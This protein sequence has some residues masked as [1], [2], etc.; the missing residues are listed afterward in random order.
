MQAPASAPVPR[1]VRSQDSRAARPPATA[2]IRQVMSWRSTHSKARL[3]AG[4]RA[5][6]LI[7]SPLRALADQTDSSFDGRLQSTWHLTSLRPPADY[8]RVP[9][10]QGTALRNEPN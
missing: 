5:A 4:L 2:S 1:C 6:V 8:R 7:D 9:V 10:I 3:L